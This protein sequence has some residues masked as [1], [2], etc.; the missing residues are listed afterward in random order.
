MSQFYR[1][2]PP[3][4]N[5][6]FISL[7]IAIDKL[8]DYKFNSIFSFS[9]RALIILLSSWMDSASNTMKLVAGVEKPVIIFDIGNNDRTKLK[10]KVT[11]N[12]CNRKK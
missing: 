11:I 7:Q 12:W 8:Q 5:F 1:I 10:N 9:A 2:S 6:H 4:L 3:V